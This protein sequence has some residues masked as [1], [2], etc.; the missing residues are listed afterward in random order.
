MK[1]QYLLG[2]LFILFLFTQ[3]FAQQPQ[4][5]VS[6]DNG[7]G[8]KLNIGICFAPTFNWM[9]P[10]IESYQPAG[11]VTNY[12]T[13]INLNINLTHG[14]NFYVSTGI[15]FE[16]LGGKMSFR[17]KIDIPG[18]TITD[19][20]QIIRTY[21]AQYLTIPTA[22][23]LKTNSIHDFYVCGNIGLY[24]SLLLKAYNIDK[25][26]FSPDGNEE[27]R[28]YWSRE[29]KPSKETSIFKQSAFAGIGLEYAVTKNFRTGLYINYAYTYTNYFKGRGEAQ[30]SLTH[31]KLKAKLGYLEIALNIN[32]F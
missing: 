12:R 32:F 15:Q 26:F 30:N 4:P 25:Y 3:A 22:I 8:A 9:Y 2:T 23:T 1:K 27:N 20:T 6:K 14:K 21:R 11:V 18:I 10:G 7:E 16:Q 31:E 29:R 17:D 5:F 13:G 19:G 28:E 24:N